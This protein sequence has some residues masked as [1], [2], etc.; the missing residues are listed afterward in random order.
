VAVDDALLQFA[1]AVRVGGVGEHLNCWA[2]DFGAGHDR[3][4][5]SPLGATAAAGQGRRRWV[6][7]T[8]ELM[9]APQRL[10]RV[11]DDP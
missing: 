6:V 11:T 4:H 3:A 9:S 2:L 7:T 10:L 5:V 1:E 8:T